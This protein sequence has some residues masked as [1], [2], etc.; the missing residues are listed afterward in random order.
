VQSDPDL[1]GH[2]AIV[3]Y[4]VEL[5]R[6][7]QDQR[8]FLPVDQPGLQRAVNLAE[9][10]RGRRRPEMLKQRDEQGCDRQADLNAL[11][12]VGHVNRFGLHRDFA[13][14]VIERLVHAVEA[15]RLGQAAAIGAQIT[16]HRFPRHVVIGK[17]EA[18]PEDR[19]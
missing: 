18:N 3:L 4:L 19:R 7:D 2:A 5:C 10:D 11:E 6:V 14:P 12:V 17:G 8:I 16:V 1:I 13:E 15:D 9:I